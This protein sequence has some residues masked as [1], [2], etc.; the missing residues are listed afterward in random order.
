ML[1]YKK[2]D[3]ILDIVI[4]KKHINKYMQ[5][6][7]SRT[8]TMQLPCGKAVPGQKLASL[9]KIMIPFCREFNEKTKKVQTPGK[10]INV[11]IKIFPNGTYQ[12]IDKLPPTV[13]LI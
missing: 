2:A 10:L 3:N 7:P 6:K 9:G 12:F 4:L 8:D 1:V 11:K 5:K 13:Y